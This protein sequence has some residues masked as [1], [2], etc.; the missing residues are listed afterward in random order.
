[1]PQGRNWEGGRVGCVAVGQEG[2]GNG[3]KAMFDVRTDEGLFRL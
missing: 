2:V 1:M 3:T